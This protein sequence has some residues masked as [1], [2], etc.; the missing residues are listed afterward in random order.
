MSTKRVVFK[1]KSSI[2]TKRNNNICVSCTDISDKIYGYSNSIG[3]WLKELD[4]DPIPRHSFTFKQ[5]KLN[6]FNDVYYPITA[7]L[8]VTVTFN[9]KHSNKLLYWAARSSNDTTIVGA[10][11]A[12]DDYQ[13]MGIV[14]INKSGSYSF[15]L[16]SPRP[17][18]TKDKVWPRHLHF[19]EI[20]NNQI[21][22]DAIV[23]TLLTLPIRKE[24]LLTPTESPNI[25]SICTRPISILNNLYIDTG[26]LINL[27]LSDNPPIF[28]CAAKDSSYKIFSDDKLIRPN[29]IQDMENFVKKTSNNNKA[30]VV[31][32]VK[33]EC[34]AGINTILKLSNYGYNNTFYYSRG[35][36]YILFDV[37]TKF[38]EAGT[39]GD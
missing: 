24:G 7:D 28:I 4:R 16:E 18:V 1:N 12:Y 26:R 27:K 11:M 34:D 37:L 36:D 30:I 22:K 21:D 14:E 35:S 29:N 3:D 17:Y 19:V 31:Y 32:C 38:S 10:E 5:L 13:N 25:K 2:R 6:D 33:E 9:K 15:K 23:Y 39:Y 8:E 20:K